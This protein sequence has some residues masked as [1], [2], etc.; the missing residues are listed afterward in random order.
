MERSESGLAGEVIGGLA[1]GARAF[2]EE[3]HA[4]SAE[5]YL[6]KGFYRIGPLM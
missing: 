2:D 5:G 4:G 3:Q 6:G 1:G